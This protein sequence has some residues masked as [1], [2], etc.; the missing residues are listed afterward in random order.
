MSINSINNMGSYRAQ[1]E[2]TSATRAKDTGGA[3]K[4]TTPPQGD[5]ISV[6]PDAMLRTEAYKVAS[7]APD[8]RQ[9]KVNSLRERVASGTYQIDNRRIASKLVQSEMALF[10]K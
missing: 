3:P 8:V 5:R 6:S 2:A 9:E 7:N 4:T 1:M 10:S